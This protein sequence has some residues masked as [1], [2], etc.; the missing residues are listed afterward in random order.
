MTE[1]RLSPSS[2]VIKARAPPYQVKLWLA[3]DRS[4]GEIDETAGPS[5]TR[6]CACRGKALASVSAATNKTVL[7]MHD[8]YTR[9]ESGG[10]DRRHG[11]APGGRHFTS[12]P[13]SSP[14]TFI[15]TSH[16]QNVALCKRR[17]LSNHT[18]PP[19]VESAI[20]GSQSTVANSMPASA[21]PPCTHSALLNRP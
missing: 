12:H 10:R 15:R 20:V 6:C 7:G 1:R 16:A 8:W 2:P 3:P 21:P 9:R 11:L 18:P 17:T 14:A 19:M 5:R 4:W 13:T